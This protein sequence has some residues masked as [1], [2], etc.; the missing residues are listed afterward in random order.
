VPGKWRKFGGFHGGTRSGSVTETFPG[1]SP[2]CPRAECGAPTSEE[3]AVVDVHRPPTARSPQVEEPDPEFWG[4][5]PRRVRRARPSPPPRPSHA[6]RFGALAD[7]WRDRFGD[8]RI[9]VGLGV[10]AVFIVAL[11]AGVV[12]YHMG[13]SGSAA[14]P[15]RP[16]TVEH[17]AAPPAT[18]T[19]SPTT[20]SRSGATTARTVSGATVIVHVA[21]A[22]KTPGVIALPVGARVIDA[23]EGAGGGLPD[24]DL[25]RLNLAAKLVDGQRIF[26]VKIGQ[27]VPMADAGAGGSVADPASGALI[28]LNTATS[29]QLETLPGIGPALAGAIITER[30]R[31]GGFRSVNELR[32]VRGIGEKRFGDLR[33]H[34][35]V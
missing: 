33:D 23:V 17:R 21:G 29:A 1:A 5:E 20:P 12:W 35:T 2:V 27:A 25:D 16:A 31:R 30:D 14:P 3:V 26:V 34:V 22:V 9:E 10:I 7:S 11:V 19:P 4:P 13:A 18:G 24:A 32:E 28:D 15:R 8:T 6:D